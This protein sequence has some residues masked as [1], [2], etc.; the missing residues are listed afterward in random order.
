MSFSLSEYIELDVGLGF[1]APDPTVGAYSTPIDS[2]VVLVKTT[3]RGWNGRGE[4]D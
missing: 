2:V 1:E 3:R 4:K